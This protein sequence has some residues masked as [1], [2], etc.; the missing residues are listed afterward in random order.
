MFTGGRGPQRG[1]AAGRR[2]LLLLLSCPGAR[3]PRAHACSNEGG[4][5]GPGSEAGKRRGRVQSAVKLADELAAGDDRTTSG[6]VGLAGNAF[7]P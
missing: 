2:R 5:G 6:L 7:E 4:G 1:G 3:P